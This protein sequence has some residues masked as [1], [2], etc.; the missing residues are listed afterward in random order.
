MKIIDNALPTNEFK[1][2]NDIMYGEMFPWFYKSKVVDDKDKSKDND[3]YQFQFVHNI[4]ENFG[5]T[6]SDNIFN[7]MYRFFNILQPCQLIRIKANLLPR[8]T[9]II[10]HGYH[11]DTH[12]W[13]ALTAIYYLNTNDGETRFESKE[14]KPV[15]SKANRLLVFPANWKHTGTTCTDQK[16]RCVINFNFI[17]YP[18]KDFSYILEEDLK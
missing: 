11:T 1:E 4:H 16:T 18:N 6:T 14:I 17:P 13:P 7:L 9:K 5:P 3:D 10:E 2:L 12:V 15:K 8:A